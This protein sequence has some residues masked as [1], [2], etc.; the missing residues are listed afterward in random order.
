MN[1]STIERSETPKKPYYR[2]AEGDLFSGDVIGEIYSASKDYIIYR[3]KGDKCITYYY[4]DNIPDFK[5]NLTK[6]GHLITKVKACIGY[7]NKDKRYL[8]MVAWF[9]KQCLLGNTE[10]A[11]KI[12]NKI[13]SISCSFR[14]NTA[15]LY[16]LVSCL[17]VV[18]LLL[19]FS[20]VQDVYIQSNYLEPYLKLMFY[21]SLGGFVSVSMSI[22]K[23]DLDIDYFSWSH[24]V[25]GVFRII[26]SMASAIISYLL[27]KSG[28]ILSN[29][30]TG[31]IYIYYLF[32]VVAGF[33]ESFIPNLLKK[34]D[35][36]GVNSDIN[37][38]RKLSKN[39]DSNNR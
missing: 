14:K 29:L 17:A 13:L 16:Y 24:T 23:L 19:I 37:S 33:S 3:R 39:E 20:F 28:L 18:A 7:E 15:R 11:N 21:G 36:Y 26:I 38:K 35:D 32:A 30:E 5:A 8:R 4:D 9:Y 6:M 34:M 22:K 25:Y 2:Y 10:I 12:C 31:N 27:I 1:S